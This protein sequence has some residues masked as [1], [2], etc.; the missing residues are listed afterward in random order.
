MSALISHAQI[1]TPKYANE[2]L[3]IGVGARAL[4]MGNTQVSFA[5][6]V[7]AG[8]WNPAG[9]LEIKQDYQ[10][11]LMHAEYFAGIANFD[12]AAAAFKL[13]DESALA[14]SMVR[15]AVDDI[16]DTRFL[17]DANGAI[18][19]DNIRFFS[20]A[21]YALFVSYAHRLK[22]EGLSIG[23]S[24]KIIHRTAGNFANAWGFGLDAGVQ[25]KKNQLSMGLVARDITGT[26]TGWWHNTE[27][28]ADVYLQTDNEIPQNSVELTVPRIA[29]GVSWRQP[30]PKSLELLW[31]ID[32]DFTFDGQRNTLLS[33]NA[34]AVDPKTGFE[35]NFK[36]MIFLR[37]G[38][39]Q[40]Q[41]IKRFDGNTDWV[42][43]PN[44]G[45]GLH[46]NK[47][48]IDYALTDLANQSPGLYS[49]IF[50]LKIALDKKK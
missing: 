32:I 40:W 20:A 34:G 5:D 45:I 28:L 31:A 43:Q 14:I 23:G 19:Y 35:F 7:T 2:F 30:L 42:F 33:Y 26:F 24:V 21:D 44:F 12:Y 39:G 17:Y 11:S 41:Q 37:G 50:S 29:Y 27:L 22:V 8:F 9:L 15:F 1:S 16:P 13:S 3:A 18:N 10:F 38:I 36:R 4:G 46:W 6:D 25:W 47:F 49:H 48:A